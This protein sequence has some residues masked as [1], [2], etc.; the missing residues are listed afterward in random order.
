MLLTSTQFK[1]LTLPLISRRMTLA[2]RPLM[3]TDSITAQTTG[4]LQLGSCFIL[5]YEYD[6]LDI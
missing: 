1:K 3:L 4:T 2:S 6:E 5:A